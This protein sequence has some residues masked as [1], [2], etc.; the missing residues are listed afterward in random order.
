MVFINQT[1]LTIELDAK[2][3][4][5]TATEVYIHYKKPSGAEGR[6]TGTASGTKITYAVEEGDINQAGMWRLQGETLIDSKVGFTDPVDFKVN[7][8]F[9]G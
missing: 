8:K 3:D 4:L 2:V 1:D 6:W 9:E 7:K 5:T